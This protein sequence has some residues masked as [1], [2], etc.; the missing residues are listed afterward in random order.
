[1]GKHYTNILRDTRGRCGAQY[2][3]FDRRHSITPNGDHH[4]M[5][6]RP[7]VTCRV[8]S[9]RMCLVAGLL[10]TYL[11][12]WRLEMTLLLPK[13]LNSVSPCHPHISW[14]LTRTWLQQG[15]HQMAT[16]PFE[17]PFLSFS[18]GILFKLVGLWGVYTNSLRHLTI[19][20]AVCLLFT[21]RA[22]L[23]PLNTLPDLHVDM[24][25]HAHIPCR[26]DLSCPYSM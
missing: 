12:S 7:L 24:I 1:M 22:S 15:D 2:P 3:C 6:A 13:D 5:H 20:I 21:I 9:R 26:H 16:A 10:V 14:L 25:C 11:Q 8:C 19:F 17:L 18:F 23:T 4:Q